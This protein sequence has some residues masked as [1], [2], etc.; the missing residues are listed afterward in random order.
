M[1]KHDFTR[2]FSVYI[3]HEAEISFIYELTQNL[4]GTISQI[5]VIIQLVLEPF[6]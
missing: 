6:K 3:V 1:E 4:T 5:M 2:K